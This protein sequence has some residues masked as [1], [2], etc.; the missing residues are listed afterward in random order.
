MHEMPA[1]APPPRL[2]NG[3]KAVNITECRCP[4]CAAP[5]KRRKIA[6]DLEWNRVAFDGQ[7]LDLTGTEAEIVHLLEA[8]RPRLVSM[9]MMRRRVFV[10]EITD[11]RVYTH[12]GRVKDKLAQI[13]LGVRLHPGYGWRLEILPDVALG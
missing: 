12:M 9:E 2:I 4:V 3:R 5:M 7:L 13:G 11:S 8:E 10:N 6:V 1:L